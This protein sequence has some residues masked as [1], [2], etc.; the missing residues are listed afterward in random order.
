MEP[1]ITGEIPVSIIA[2]RP[3]RQER[4]QN[5]TAVPCAIPVANTR[6]S[7]KSL[8]NLAFAE[9]LAFPISMT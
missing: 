4:V 6:K 3:I 8:L 5:L 7:L 2:R 1:D 9:I